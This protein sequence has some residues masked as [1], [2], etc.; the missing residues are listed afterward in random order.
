M[1]ACT[2]TGVER[3]RVIVVFPIE[4]RTMSPSV[5]TMRALAPLLLP[6][7]TN[8]QVHAFVLEPDPIWIESIH[9]AKILI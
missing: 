8:V 5:V 7:S 6:E 2:R 3:C 9:E 1:I 4:L